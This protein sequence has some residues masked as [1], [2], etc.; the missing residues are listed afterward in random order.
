LEPVMPS[1]R[2][3]EI[4]RTGDVHLFAA[5]FRELAHELRSGENLPLNCACSRAGENVR[6]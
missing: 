1:N 2:I 6:A 5:P 3:E 4:T